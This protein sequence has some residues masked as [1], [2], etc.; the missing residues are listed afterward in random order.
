MSEETAQPAVTSRSVA[1]GLGTTVLARLGAVVE[2]VAQPLYVLMFGLAGYGLYAVLW[3]TINLLENIFDTGMTSAMQRTVPQSASD[4][5]AA[6]ALRTAMIFGVGPCLIV[7]ALIAVF[8]ADLAPFLNVAEKDRPLVVPAIQLF[9]W[10]LPLWAFVEIA[11]SAMRARMVFGAEIRLRIVWEQIMRLVFAGLFF[12][13]G[14]G[15][16]GLFLAHLCSLAI[17][18]LLCVRLLRRY[19]SFADLGRD[20]WIGDT[21]RDTFW[22]GVSILPSNIIAR[23]FGDAPALILNL[24]LPGAA[25]A[26]ASGLFTIA[27]KLSSVVQLVR[28]AFVYV[29]A[30]LAASAEREDRAQVTDIY[31]YATRLIAAIALPLAAVLAA[32]S[33]SLLS[34]FGDQAQVAQ[35]ALVIL[36][37]ARAAEAVLGISLPVLQV[38]AAFRHQLTASIF[39]VIVAV[40][41]GWLIVGHMDALTGVTLA[42]SIGLVVMGGIPMIQLAVNERLHPF[43]SQFPAVAVRGLTVTLVAGA[44]AL[45][46]SRLPDPVALPLITA[47]AAGAIWTSLRLALPEADRASLGKTGRRLR[48]I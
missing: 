18:A 30:P 25:G 1:R 33:S 47:L 5:D 15:L 46:I 40:A 21:V 37:F 32:G 45:A 13:G 31:A 42:M 11:T 8:A 28:I 7:A 26:A 17:T 16:K 43:D 14:L 10:A 39:G 29:M 24:L 27:R 9:V 48:L 6:A 4:A 36:L 12:A 34:L 44:L 23:L 22:A 38:V 2:I 20:P 41:S 35:A 19:Y 3:A